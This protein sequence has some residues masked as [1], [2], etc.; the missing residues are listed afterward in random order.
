MNLFEAKTILQS[1]GY[2]VK[3]PT[4]LDEVAAILE[5]AKNDLLTEMAMNAPKTEEGKALLRAKKS[6]DSKK[7][8][9]GASGSM[10]NAQAYINAYNALKAKEDEI[11]GDDL[12]ILKAFEDD[13]YLEAAENDD[14]SLIQ[15][16]NKGN[17]ARADKGGNFAQA[18]EAGNVERCVDCLLNSCRSGSTSDAGIE[19]LRNRLE[20]VRGMKGAEAAKIAGKIAQCEMKI[21]AMSAGE[22]APRRRNQGS[23]TIDLSAYEG[24]PALVKAILAKAGVNATLAEDGSSISIVGTSNAIA[25]ASE[26]LAAHPK[27]ADLVVDVAAKEPVNRS[28]RETKVFAVE[29]TDIAEV[30]LTDLSEVTYEIDAESKQVSI[31]GTPKWI[32]KAVE[33]IQGLGCGCDAIEG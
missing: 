28:Q 6:M 15:K 18:Y 30:A 25:K 10:A 32:A 13:G 20:L 29:D 8:R 4:V 7:S 12:D 3:K 17:G 33:T 24:N 26:A 9:P 22:V 1:I 11:D 16:K 5:S 19:A 27:T 21:G 31:T 23:A 14:I 2:T